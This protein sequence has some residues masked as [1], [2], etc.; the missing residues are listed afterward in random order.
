MML[1]RKILEIFEINHNI[2]E[3][4]VIEFNNDDICREIEEIS[5]IRRI[6]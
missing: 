2:N 5:K 3:K 1:S 6:H 4:D